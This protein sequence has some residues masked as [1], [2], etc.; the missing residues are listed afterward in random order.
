MPYEEAEMVIKANE[1]L[2]GNVEYDFKSKREI[3][4][5]LRQS[6]PVYMGKPRLGVKAGSSQDDRRR[7]KVRAGELIDL[8]VA[9]NPAAKPKEGEAFEEEEDTVYSNPR[10]RKIREIDQYDKK[11]KNKLKPTT[12]KKETPKNKPTTESGN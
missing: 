9:G 4:T 12:P 2:L 1:L 5:V 10:E 6:P 8:W 11:L 7:Y 3:G